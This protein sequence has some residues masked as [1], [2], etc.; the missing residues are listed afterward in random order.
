MKPLL[1]DDWV[2]SKLVFPLIGQPKVDGVRALNMVGKLTARS[3]KP[4]K[5]KYLTARYLSLIHI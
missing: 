3:L 2:E 5:N 4:F 1:A